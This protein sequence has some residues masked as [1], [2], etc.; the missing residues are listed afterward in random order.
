MRSYSTIFCSD[1]VTTFQ[2]FLHYTFAVISGLRHGSQC[3]LTGIQRIRGFLLGVTPAQRNR[4]TK[5]AVEYCNEAAVLVVV[6]PA[7]D[8]IVQKGLNKVTFTLVFWSGG[9]SVVL[10]IL[11]AILS[12]K[13]P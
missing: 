13:E 2:R 6:F 7:L 12:L 9:I 1:F 4:I 3:M 10:F 8:V 11:G 5:L